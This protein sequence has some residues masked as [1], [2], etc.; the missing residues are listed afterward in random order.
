[1]KISFSFLL[2]FYAVFTITAQIQLPNNYKN[3]SNSQS[4]SF[5]LEN[6]KSQLQQNGD[7]V[8]LPGKR[9]S[10]V[11]NGD[12]LVLS[13][14]YTVGWYNKNSSELTKQVIIDSY[15]NDSLYK[16]SYTYDELSVRISA[17]FETYNLLENKWKIDYRAL[18]NYDD[19]KNVDT[20]IIQAWESDNNQWRDSIAEVVDWIDTVQLRKYE[21][22]EIDEDS[23]NISFGYENIYF[24]T[25]EGFI[26]EEYQD[27]YNPET[28][29]WER[30][31]KVTYG[32]NEDGS[33]NESIAHFW[34]GTD[35]EWIAT[36]KQT[37]SDWVIFHR[38]PYTHYNRIADI[39]FFYYIDDEW[40]KFSREVSDYFNLETDS[41]S[42]L[43]YKWMTPGDT[44]FVSDSLFYL[45]NA[46]GLKQRYWWKVRNSPNEDFLLKFDDSVTWQYYKGSLKEIYR[47]TFDTLLDDWRPAARVV[48]SD[49][50]PYVDISRVEEIQKDTGNLHLIPNPADDSF[51]IENNQ[52]ITEI[53]IFHMNGKTIRRD[54][55][56]LQLPT[57]RI[58]VTK[59]PPGTYVVKAKTADNKL[60]GSKLVVK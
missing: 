60:L 38:Y 22:V 32:L 34:E 48:Y 21:I 31:Q 59:L 56:L 42:R 16:T 41:F 29:N 51:F 53:T 7:T 20:L 6:Y 37:V 46:D 36:N 18:Y 35:Q 30:N 15:N 8:W 2:Q 45:N 17:L 57:I 50:V 40:F 28:Q 4:P 25:E 27:V 11:W 49:F 19:Y 52:Q 33:W 58:D 12:S 1:M 9:T 14:T 47:I 39:S 23:W 3:V 5:G 13:A 10:Y 43:I 24:Y 54:V 55:D 44:M 26:F